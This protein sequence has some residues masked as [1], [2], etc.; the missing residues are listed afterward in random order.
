MP[1]IPLEPPELDSCCPTSYHRVTASSAL[2]ATQ[3]CEGQL[4]PRRRSA[5]AVLVAVPCGAGSPHLRLPGCHFAP[6]V[7]C[8][9]RWMNKRW[10]RK[11]RK[12]LSFLGPA[13]HPL[14]C[15]APPQSL[16]R[17]VLQQRIAREPSGWSE[18]HPTPQNPQWMPL[19][20]NK[21]QIVAT[22]RNIM[23]P[24]S[25]KFFVTFFT[26]RGLT[27]NVQ[28]TQGL[29]LKGS[30]CCNMSQTLPQFIS[31]CVLSRSKFFAVIAHCH[32]HLCSCRSPT[33][34]RALAQANV[35]QRP[36]MWHGQIVYSIH[37]YT[38]WLI[39]LQQYAPIYS[40]I[41]TH[42]YTPQTHTQTM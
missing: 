17:T 35:S 28:E 30:V 2:C 6:R 42:K 9:G 22:C 12:L 36:L 20:A 11:R 23:D 21:I 40:S 5:H 33:C 38:K 25:G 37:I 39:H 14:Q 1:S 29:K 18:R 7:I 41:Y 19:D 26:R 4:S 8:F 31:M 15:H 27:D 34:I 24:K 16:P 32:V 13:W 10:P 3:G